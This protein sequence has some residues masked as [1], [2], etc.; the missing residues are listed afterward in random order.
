M[1]KKQ[2][3]V[4]KIGSSLLA[5]SDNLTLRYAFM[6][7]LMSDLAH[8][9]REGHDIVLTSSGSV[10]L[11]LNMIGKRP[12]DAGI[13][14]KQAAAAC[15]QPLLMNAY[16][17]VA[18][19]FDLDVAQMLVTVEDM[20]ERRRFLNIKNT[21]FRLFENDILP[22]INENDSVATR[23]LRVGDNDRLSA[24]VAQMIEA[25]LLIILTSVEGLYDR[26]PSDPDATF[27][28]EIED[29]SEHLESTTGISALGSGGMLTKMQA[30]NMAQNA[31]VE[32]I[33]AEGIIERPVSS[34]LNKER[35]FTRCL[36]TGET[37][38]PLK[39]W[40]SNRLQV[41]GT[42][43]VS[44]ALAADL[45]KK[46]RG[47]SRADVISLQGDFL[48]G[49]VLHVYS[50]DG[51]EVARGLTNF[52]SEE[53]LLMARNLDRPVEDVIGYKTQSN[54]IGA[55]N[56]L[57]LMDNHLPLDAPAQ[58]QKVVIPV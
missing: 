1:S 26:D 28:S 35:R 22:I 53:T 49:D 52:S 57:V 34:V 44:N 8:L 6:N 54:I 50:E 38:S 7:G 16:R 31:G 14:D 2:K 5:N 42:L 9:Q 20:E 46:D 18:S 4:V 33:I 3:I 58:D 37:A 17:Q 27:I 48:K 12:E 19:E 24:K 45:A 40:L 41:S 39:V 25:D 30:A 13:L 21:M 23:D 10:A 32:T 29:V 47:I 36:V 56:I 55:E 51:E 43:V 11:G 15:G